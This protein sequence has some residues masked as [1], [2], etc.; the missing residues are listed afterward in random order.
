M[1]DT[2]DDGR[3]LL[4]ERI[5]AGPGDAV[6]RATL[7]SD[8][9]TRLLVTMTGPHRTPRPFPALRIDGV[10]A[11]EWFGPGPVPYA[12]ALVERLPAGDPALPLVPLPDAA[13]IAL[14][15]AIANVVAAAHRGGERIGGIRPELIYVTGDATFTGL[16]PRGPELIATA[17]QRGSGLRSYHVPYL[18]PEVLGRLAPELASDVFALGASLFSL[19]IGEHPF[20]DPLEPMEVLNRILTGRVARWPRGDALGALL[21]AAMAPRATDRPRADELAARLASLA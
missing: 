3:I 11:V 1:A 5:H 7:A 8:P 14:G 19:G 2:L 18:A 4:G 10:A 17:P 16:V 15:V 20:G 21:A 12:E 13:L 6:H 9:N